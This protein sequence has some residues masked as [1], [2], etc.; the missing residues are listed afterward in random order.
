MQI[1]KIENKCT[2]AKINKTKSCFFK[3][4]KP[5]LDWRKK[6]KETMQITKLQKKITYLKDIKNNKKDII[7]TL[8]P[9]HL[10]NQVKWKTPLENTLYQIWLGK[11]KYLIYFI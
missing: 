6:K 5:Y 7:N 1:N 8:M 3:K 10:N 4:D 11:Q 9:I 2:T